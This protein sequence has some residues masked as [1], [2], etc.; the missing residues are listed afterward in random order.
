MSTSHSNPDN[1]LV[2]QQS[3]V[4]TD[5][6]GNTPLVRLQYLP[7]IEGIAPSIELLAKLE[8]NNPA[9]SVKDRPALNMVMQAE[10]RGEIAPGDTLI[11][12]TSGNTGIALAMVAA[13]R[14]YKLILLMPTNST[15]ER[16]DA[17]A[18]YGATLIE[19]DEGIEAA[20]DDALKLQ[21]QGAGKVLDQ[22]SNFDNSAAHYMTTGP[23][24]WQQTN[25]HIT[26]FISSMGTTGTISGTGK[27]LKEQNPNIQV[28]GLQPDADASIAG[29]R[30]WAADYRPAIFNASVVDTIMD[31]NQTTAE[32]YMRK[33]ARKEG[34]LAGVS[35]GAAAWAA[36][37]VAKQ[38]Q[39]EQ[40]DAVIVFI[41]CDRGDRYLSTGLYRQEDT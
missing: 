29:I 6:V 37:E 21:A 34:I 33:L 2:S 16:K 38:I 1:V 9:S 40:P 4:L 14:G 27:Y 28:I 36:L 20:R 23:E 39:D 11:E 10:K 5:C 8:G 32:Q 12:A 3:S 25:G 13:M 41:T 18:A 17:M 26:H 24:I 30:R 22:F 35:S 15:Q 7:E 31:I 19:V